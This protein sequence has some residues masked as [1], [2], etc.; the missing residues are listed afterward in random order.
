MDTDGRKAMVT[1]PFSLD[2][3]RLSFRV[4]PRIILMSNVSSIVSNTICYQIVIFVL[5]PAY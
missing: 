4:L 3:S 5:K 1:Q 2:G